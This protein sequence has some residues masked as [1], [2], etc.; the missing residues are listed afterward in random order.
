MIRGLRKCFAYKILK[1]SYSYFL[2][3]LKQILFYRRK[4][5]ELAVYYEKINFLTRKKQ[6]T[7]RVLFVLLCRFYPYSLKVKA[8]VTVLLSRQHF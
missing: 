3:K 1:H 7:N 2:W 5:E 4:F 8:F 6:T